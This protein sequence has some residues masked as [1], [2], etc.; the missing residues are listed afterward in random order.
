[1]AS[2][3]IIFGPQ[4]RQNIRE[5]PGREVTAAGNWKAERDG[6]TGMKSSVCV[7]SE[8]IH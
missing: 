5:W 3:P 8:L 6:L 7:I 1:M 2:V 4:L